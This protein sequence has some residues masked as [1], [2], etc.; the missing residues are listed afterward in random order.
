MEVFSLK[1]RDLVNPNCDP[2]CNRT[3]TSSSTMDSVRC[4]I[5][6]NPPSDVIFLWL[7]HQRE[8]T[9]KSVVGLGG[10]G[11]HSPP[12]LC[13]LDHVKVLLDR[14]VS[15]TPHPPPP[16]P[17]SFITHGQKRFSVPPS[18]SRGPQF[19]ETHTRLSLHMCYAFFSSSFISSIQIE[20]EQT[21][22]TTTD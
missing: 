12:S 22:Y 2:S 3:V 17:P 21:G 10:G 6:N 4:A 1:G 5:S 14:E 20:S 7:F 13:N 16:L 11:F 19:P 9:T 18:S 8:T 15:H